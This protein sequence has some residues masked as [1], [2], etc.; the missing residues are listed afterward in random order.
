MPERQRFEREISDLG[1]REG[2]EF[3]TSQDRNAW[4]QSGT[5]LGIDFYDRSHAH[6]Q[7][8]GRLYVQSSA[9]QSEIR[10]INRGDM[11]DIYTA[12]RL[13]AADPS[14]FAYS[15]WGSTPED[16]LFPE[17]AGKQPPFNRTKI[18]A[19][20]RKQSLRVD[21][22]NDEKQ[23]KFLR[24]L[25]NRA[26]DKDVEQG[27]YIIFNVLPREG[28]AALYLLRANPVSS[29]STHFQTNFA[30]TG[31]AGNRVRYHP[32]D[33]NKQIIGLVHTHYLKKNQVIQASTTVGTTWKAGEER[34]RMVHAVSADD[35]TSA[36]DNE[37]I[38]YA[39]EGDQI[40]TA[41][42]DGRAI[43]AVRWPSYNLLMDALETFS[44]KKT[45]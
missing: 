29:S 23:T 33:Q 43:N 16:R 2:R 45:P 8:L 9:N 20:A 22:W 10:L 37:F 7:Y 27:A 39:L 25:Y 1:L 19:Q 6:L 18:E 30:G 32:N 44:G 17:N 34:K 5:K 3:D 15:P 4:M 36:R 41:L 40:H 12:N 13:S 24:K 11:A 38:V 14:D 21:V 26:K 31:P 42:P 35:I 28:R